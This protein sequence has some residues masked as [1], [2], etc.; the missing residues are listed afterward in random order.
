MPVR[1]LPHAISAKIAAGEVIERPASVVKEL[2]ENALDAAAT[3]VVVEVQAGGTR[4]IRVRDDGCG[5]PAEEV[6]LAFQRHATSKIAETDDLL[7]LT[8]LGFRGEALPSV[9][10][11]AEVTFLTRPAQAVAGYAVHYEGGRLAKEG[12]RGAAPGTVVTVR[13]LFADFPARRKFLRSPATE[14]SH[15]ATVVSQYALARPSVAFTL[16]VDG[17]RTLVTP[18]DGDLRTAV[19]AVLGSAI[20]EALLNVAEPDGA[21]QALSVTG[22]VSPP[23]ITRASRGGISI[24]VNE[25]WVQHR[26]L[27]FAVEEAYQNAL[28]VGRHPIAV[29]RL[30]V[31]AEEVDVNVHPRK[32]ELR[33]RYEGEVFAAVQAAVRRTLTSASL[34]AHVQVG[35]ANP[36]SGAVAA[37]PWVGPETARHAALFQLPAAEQAPLP[38]GASEAMGRRLPLLRVM[39]QVGATY[40]IAEGPDGVYLIDQHAA[41]ERVLFERI[42]DRLAQQPWEQQGLLEPRLLELAADEAPLIAQA[43]DLLEAHGFSIEEF[44]GRQLLL[45]SIP[46]GVRED[47]LDQLLAEVLAGLRATDPQDA[48]ATTMA[49]HSAVRA[50]DPLSGDAMRALVQDMERCRAPQTCPHGRPTTMHLSATQLEREFGRRG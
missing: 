40:I 37:R 34:D 17:K 32:M 11:V 15:C 21:A 35:G 27:A 14:A 44:G 10:A 19:A 13:D 31:P 18:G 9:A 6:A 42:Q 50:G 28:M 1:V 47:A 43:Q 26:A 3:H 45:R 16:L 30:A 39:G 38:A 12:A 24:F 25:R 29:L 5:L 22:L 4:L 8:S 46:A 7:R 49:C 2:L 36:R 23:G 48:L 33:F 20:G 41:H